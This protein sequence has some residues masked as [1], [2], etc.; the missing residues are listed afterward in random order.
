[1]TKQKPVLP[2]DS[3]LRVLDPASG[4]KTDTRLPRYE[5]NYYNNLMM[6]RNIEQFY[7]HIGQCL[8]F[9]GFSEYSFS[10]LSAR[11]EILDPLFTMPMG[12]NNA[13]FS[14]NLHE[15]DPVI[16]YVLCNDKPIF[17]SD[18][19]RSIESLPYETETTRH[20]KEMFALL[21]AYGYTDFYYIPIGKCG[22]DGKVTLAVATKSP[23][24]DEFHNLVEKVK[25]QL[26][27]LARAIGFTGTKKFPEFFLG[28]LENKQILINPNFLQLLQIMLQQD[29]KLVNA[30]KVMNVSRHTANRWIKCIKD[31]LRVNT[32]ARAIYLLL[33][34]G[35]IKEK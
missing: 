24:V 35:L 9:M 1:M 8:R 11:S 21:N 26:I 12:M 22:R 7:N 4:E 20:N 5:S 23:D 25:L 13:Y 30:A 6:A 27:A 19:Q 2:Y 28:D 34:A 15:H 31:D 3:L 32:T 14:E 16:Q 33:K 10:R 17:L 18:I 29:M